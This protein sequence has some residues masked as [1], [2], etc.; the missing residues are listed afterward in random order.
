MLFSTLSAALVSL[1]VPI[2]EKPYMSQT[3]WCE[4]ALQVEVDA[5]SAVLIDDNE[6][7]IFRPS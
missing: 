3:E 5:H 1:R 6:L 4:I 2:V 7:L